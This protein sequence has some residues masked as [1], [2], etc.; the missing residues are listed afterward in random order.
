MSLQHS[1]PFSPNFS[2]VLHLSST[3]LSSAPQQILLPPLQFLSLSFIFVCFISDEKQ[4]SHF[5]YV[6]ILSLSDLKS[7][8]LSFLTLEKG[9]RSMWKECGSCADII[10]CSLFMKCKSNFNILGYSGSLKANVEN[11]SEW[12]IWNTCMMSHSQI[13]WLPF[14]LGIHKNTL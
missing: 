7:A 12:Y 3:P 13:F 5:S 11:E 8:N 2:Q 14:F 4:N 6:F 1:L 10:S 9:Q